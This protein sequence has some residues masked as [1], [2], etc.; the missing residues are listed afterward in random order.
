MQ[1]V[2]DRPEAPFAIRN[3]LGAILRTPGS[4]V[5]APTPEEEDHRRL[6]RERK[7]L[8]AERVFF[9]SSNPPQAGSWCSPLC[10]RQPNVRLIW[11]EHPT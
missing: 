10:S 7:V 1:T 8:T 2:A 11:E 3:D 9:L 5:N 4:M 6:C